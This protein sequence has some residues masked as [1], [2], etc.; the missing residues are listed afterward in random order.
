MVLY[1]NDKSIEFEIEGYQ[2]PQASD[3]DY[4]ANWL[5][6]RIKYTQNG[7]SEEYR[8]ACLQTVELSELAD[9]LSDIIDGNDN[10][11]ISDFLEP[12]IRISI[13]RIEG[14]IMFQFHYFYDASKEVWRERK[15]VS[16]LDVNKSIEILHFLHRM[17]EMYPVR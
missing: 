9:V 11:Y 1:E 13:A 12:Y 14:Q 4:D 2:Y 3:L 5:L 10:G 17:V 15:V 8:D 16:S 6:C 7:E